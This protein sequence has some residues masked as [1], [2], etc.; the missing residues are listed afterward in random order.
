MYRLE[1]RIRYEI[2][3][4]QQNMTSKCDDEERGPGGMTLNYSAQPMVLQAALSS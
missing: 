3:S 1:K 2:Q 4:K